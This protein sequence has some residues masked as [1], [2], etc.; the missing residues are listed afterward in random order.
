MWWV[1]YTLIGKIKHSGITRH[2][3]GL[4]PHLTPCT[5]RRDS[6]ICFA[7][8]EIKIDIQSDDLIRVYISTTGFS[9]EPKD[10]S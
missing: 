6:A 9:E 7:G 2:S 5:P 8:Q 3:V 1:N 4:V 10:I